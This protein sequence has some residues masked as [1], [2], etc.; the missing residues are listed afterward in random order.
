MNS[1]K[2]DII[3]KPNHV[4][5]LETEQKDSLI[6]TDQSYLVNKPF[7]YLCYIIM[8]ST[9]RNILLSLLYIAAFIL[10]YVYVSPEIPVFLWVGLFIWIIIRNLIDR[11]N[12]LVTMKFW[13]K[14]LDESTFSWYVSR[15]ES[16][17][18]IHHLAKYTGILTKK[19][20]LEE[21]EILK[22]FSKAVWLDNPDLSPSSNEKLQI[23]KE[24]VAVIKKI[25][26]M[27]DSHSEDCPNNPKN[28]KKP[29]KPRTT[30]R[31]A[32]KKKK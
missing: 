9:T 29:S 30:K 1:E 4:A 3:L 8:K 24:A 12:N 7:Y 22:L 21:T 32:P 10:S 17:G 18:I 6:F 11:K 2:S 31:P 5:V 15:K 14:D 16:V 19:Y 25:H 23:I 20:N 27:Q 13:G 28:I 26:D